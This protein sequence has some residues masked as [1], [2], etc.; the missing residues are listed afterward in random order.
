M[1]SW[2]FTNCPD[3]GRDAGLRRVGVD[4]APRSWFL[5]G[6]LIVPSLD[7]FA[8]L[9]FDCDGTLADSMPIHYRAWRATLD[10]LG[11]DFP[12]ETF[13][14]WGGTPAREIVARL[15]EAQG[16]TLDAHSVAEEKEELYLTYLD[17]VDR[18]EPV[19][20]V[21]ERAAQEGRVVAC[22]SG[23]RR[24]IVEH[25][26]DLIGVRSIMHAVIGAEDYARGKPFPDPFLAAA[27]K[28][29]VDPAECLVFEDTGTGEAAA[30]AA[31]MACVR[32]DR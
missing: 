12:R 15:A 29:G 26:L 1:R 18:I 16:R 19:C 21:A 22:V 17:R 11:L 23:G 9:L 31:G 30:T 24:A 10:P 7:S 3:G 4:A 8:A 28:L 25:T 5:P 27:R 6:V 20:L 13:D 2:R 32:V 14:A